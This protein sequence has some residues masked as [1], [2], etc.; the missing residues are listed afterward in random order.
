MGDQDDGVGRLV[1]RGKTCEVKAATPKGDGGFG[2]GARNIRSGSY[3]KR[4]QRK[5]DNYG[6]N[7]GYG[8][9]PD[10]YAYLEHMA[11]IPVM[12]DG[13]AYSH[14]PQLQEYH[15][16]AISDAGVPPFMTPVYYPS[17]PY[18]HTHPSF[19]MPPPPE[20]YS[21]G[22]SAY[23]MVPPTP[24]AAAH[25]AVPLPHHLSATTPGGVVPMTSPPAP[26]LLPMHH[27]PYQQ[28]HQH[29][30]PAPYSQ[31]QA[32]YTFLP[33]APMPP[34]AGVAPGPPPGV[35]VQAASVMQPVAPGLPYKQQHDISS[36]NDMENNI[37][38]S[39]VTQK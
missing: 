1:M 33:V 28:H 32:A 17:V 5:H 10:S 20:E 15:G 9:M 37:G 35:V 23:N 39:S 38:G 14:N 27:S 8:P 26:L 29:L 6:N 36:H 7:I 11:Y 24:D 21:H 2:R 12:H 13:V 25:F 34:R 19:V 3:Q 22:G 16:T 31:Q 30:T 18:P 4:E